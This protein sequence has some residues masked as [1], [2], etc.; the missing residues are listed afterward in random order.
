[1]TFQMDSVL[2]E[3]ANH[4]HPPPTYGWYWITWEHNTHPA[5]W[6]GRHWCA[7]PDRPWDRIQIEGWFP[8]VLPL[9]PETSAEPCD[10]KQKP[11]ADFVRRL[12]LHREVRRE[13]L[14]FFH[15]HPSASMSDVNFHLIE[16]FGALSG[17]VDPEELMAAL[18]SVV[19]WFE[20]L[21]ITMNEGS[22]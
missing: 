3:P 6:D 8:M 7:S 5:Y 15:S 18:T 9:G 20:Q 21:G 16:E 13:A 17:P 2:K 10:A 22:Q 14:A 1:M 19:E 12:A 4:T 11:V